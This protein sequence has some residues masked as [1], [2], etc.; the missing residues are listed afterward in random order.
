MVATGGLLSLA[1]IAA[2]SACAPSGPLDKAALKKLGGGIYYMQGGAGH[3]DVSSVRHLDLASGRAISITDG[4]KA[5]FVYGLDAPGRTL[6][7]TIDDDLYLAEPDG[8]KLRKVASSSELDWYPRFAP[9]A[10]FVV[11]ESARDSFRDLYR[12]NLAT[13][14][15]TR[16]TDNEEG[17]FDAAWSP[18]GSKL[19]FASSRAGQLD[20]WVMNA[21]GTHPRR[22]T[23]HAGDSVK[24]QW[25][26]SGR[27]IAFISGRDGQDDLFVV[28]PQGTDIRKLNSVARGPRKN[29][30]QVR[31]F[32]W[33]PSADRI[34]FAAQ[35]QRAPS[36]IHT[37]DASGLH[38]TRLSKPN[39]DE[40]EPTWSP[41]GEHL[42]FASE[43]DDGSDIYIMRADGTRRT[44][45][46]HHSARAWLPRWDRTRAKE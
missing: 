30:A 13:G 3:D 27:Y 34:A 11:F 7:L 43:R 28:T 42:A 29:I 26:P 38:L 25:S 17:N 22:L 12:L 36:Q 18:D 14:K 15:T 9:N 40:R 5:A 35:A 39:Y 16:L 1:V 23:R 24:P 20:V 6:A 2:C 41:D 4:S 44:R 10:Q 33:H 8:T 32:A 21:D 37:V 45:V 46:T 31:R 19:A